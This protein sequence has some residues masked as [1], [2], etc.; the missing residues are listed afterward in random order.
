MFGYVSYKAIAAALTKAGSTD[1][2]KI[3][4][5]LADLTIPTPVGQ[6]TFRAADN[7]ATLTVFTGKL[8]KQNGKGVMVD[9]IAHDGAKLLP[10]P[11]DAAKLRPKS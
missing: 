5:A 8:E 9:W 7:Q 11:A 2:E 4:D 10:P 1:P 3:V 6:V